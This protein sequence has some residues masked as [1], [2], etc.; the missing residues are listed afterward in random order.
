MASELGA[1]GITVNTIAPGYMDAGM[2]REIPEEMRS[3]L[4]QTIPS[5][6]L[7]NSKNIAELVVFLIK[8]NSN[9]MNGQTISVNGGMV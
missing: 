6:E 3:E 4:L 5:H 8:E 7:G 2:I 1:T 9:Y